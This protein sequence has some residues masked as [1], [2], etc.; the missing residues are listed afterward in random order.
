MDTVNNPTDAK[1]YAAGAT[2]VEY[3]HVLVVASSWDWASIAGVRVGSGGVT[4][5]GAG[6]AGPSFMAARVAEHDGG[7]SGGPAG[8]TGD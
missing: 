7:S 2:V 1:T 3:R 5:G 4:W 6:H 8:E